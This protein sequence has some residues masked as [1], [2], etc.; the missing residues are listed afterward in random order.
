MTYLLSFFYYFYFVSTERILLTLSGDPQ[1]P[2]GQFIV[3]TREEGLVYS[4]GET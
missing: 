2:M 3:K 4:W 1:A